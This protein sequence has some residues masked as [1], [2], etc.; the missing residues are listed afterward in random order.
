MNPTPPAKSPTLIYL[1]SLVGSLG[2]VFVLVLAMK[3]YTSPAPLGA[4]R[5]ALR[6]KNLEEQRNADTFVLNHYAWQDSEKGVVRLTIE[7]A[8][9]L[10]VQEYK[11]PAAARARTVALADKVFA[12]PPEKPS[13]FE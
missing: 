4:D 1:L 12:P 2:I 6:K 10:T 5:T 13:E 8:M 7:R 9:E 3:H 11:D